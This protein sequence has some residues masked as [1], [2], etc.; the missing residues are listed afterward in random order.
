M[1][2]A[3]CVSASCKLQRVLDCMDGDP[4]PG[5][6]PGSHRPSEAVFNHSNVSEAG[7]IGLGFSWCSGQGSGDGV[8]D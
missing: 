7:M 4:E 6:E 1:W 8:G 3:S 5:S 2:G